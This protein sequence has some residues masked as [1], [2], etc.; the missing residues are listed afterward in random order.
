MSRISLSRR[1]MLFALGASAAMLPSLRGGIIKTASAAP[2][3]TTAPRRLVFFMTQHGTVY[4]SWKMPQAGDDISLAGL[5]SDAQMSRILKPLFPHRA[6]LCV[7]DGIFMMSARLP[8]RYRESQRAQHRT[9]ACVDGTDGDAAE[10]RG[11]HHDRS[12]DRRIAPLEGAH[13]RRERRCRRLRGVAVQ[14][15]GAQRSRTGTRES[16]DGVRRTLR[17]LRDERFGSP[18]EERTAREHPRFRA[19]RAERRAGQSERDRQDS[20]RCASAGRARLGASSRGVERQ[21]RRARASRVEQT[22]AR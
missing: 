22:L 13:Q 5:T 15:H 4:D 3:S 21:L 18:E 16:A 10:P 11:G 12:V 9:G 1:Q 6:D 8:R 20:A 14:L 17:R 2:S 19:G 7:L